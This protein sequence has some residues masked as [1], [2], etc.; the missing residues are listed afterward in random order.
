M[1]RLKADDLVGS[2]GQVERSGGFIQP[3]PPAAAS[4]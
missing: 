3:A 2:Q 1:Q 4:A